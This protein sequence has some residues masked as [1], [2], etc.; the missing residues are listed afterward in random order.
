MSS[1]KKEKEMSLE[2]LIFS[3][4]FCTFSHDIK[5]I[6]LFAKQL[7]GHIEHR[8]VRATYFNGIFKHFKTLFQKSRAQ[9]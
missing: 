6:N 1:V 8:D 2:K 5:N 3:T 7:C 9:D 4:E